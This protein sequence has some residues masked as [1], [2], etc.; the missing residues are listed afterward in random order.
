MDIPFTRFTDRVVRRGFSRYVGVVLTSAKISS[1]NAVA[2]ALYV[3]AEERELGSDRSSAR[4][5]YYAGEG[6]WHGSADALAAAGLAGARMDAAT[7]EA[8]LDGRDP[9]TGLQLRRRGANGVVN[10]HDL[11]FA[12]PKPVSTLWAGSSAEQRQLLEQVIHRAHREAMRYLVDNT[13]CVHQRAEG[14]SA[15]RERVVARELVY[16]SMLHRTARPTPGADPDPHLHIHT[17]IVGAIRDRDGRLVTPDSFGWRGYRVQEVGAVFEA[18]VGRQL[19]ELGLPTRMHGAWRSGFAIEGIESS[20]VDALSKRAQQ[21]QDALARFRDE[22]QRSPSR[23]EGR[24]LGLVDRQAKIG[25]DVDRLEATW[26]A[27]LAEHGVD[28]PAIWNARTRQ[29][30]TT[31]HVQELRGRLLDEL[32]GHA[33]ISDEQLRQMALR[34]GSGALDAKQTLAQ[35]EELRRDGQILTLESGYVTSAAVRHAERMTLDASDELAGL[36]LDRPAS[37][38]RTFQQVIGEIERALPGELSVEQCDAA[39]RTSVDGRRLNIVVGK[40][41]SGKGEVISTISACA[42]DAGQ[43]V[44]V[45]AV[46]GG[47]AQQA[48]SDALAPARTIASTLARMDRG[49]EPI[50]EG[51]VLIVDEA[52]MVDTHQLWDLLDRAADR[53]LQV[54]LVGDLAQIQAIGPGGMLA[55]LIERHGCIELTE[56][57]RARHA[58]LRHAQLAIREARASE[59][60]ATY[61]QHGALHVLDTTNDAIAQMVERWDTHRHEHKLAQSLMIVHDTNVTVDLVNM[62]AQERRL[63]AGELG[64]RSAPSPDRDYQLYE[65]DLVVFRNAPYDVGDGSPRVEN[66][67]R[68]HIRRIDEDGTIHVLVQEP[69]Q[70]H[71]TIAVDPDR[72]PALRLA[73]A[74]HTMPAQGV[75]VERSYELLN[76]HAINRHN[77][78]VGASRA[79]ERHDVF[80]PGDALD[81]TGTLTQAQMLQRL[82]GA[83]DS[84]TQTGASLTLEQIDRT[85]QPSVMPRTHR[86]W[87]APEIERAEQH[88]HALTATARELEQQLATRSTQREDLVTRRD[89]T[90]QAL[91]QPSAQLDEATR[92]VADAQARADSARL[93]RGSKEWQLH[94]E[95][96]QLHSAQ[97]HFKHVNEAATAAVR[98]LSRHDQTTSRLSEQLDSIR[99]QIKD[100]QRALEFAADPALATRELDRIRHQHEQARS[101]PTGYRT[102]RD[103]L[104]AFVRANPDLPELR[105]SIGP[106]P[107]EP[108]QRGSWDTAATAILSHRIEHRIT[109]NKTTLGPP[110]KTEQALSLSRGYAAT[111]EIVTKAA[112]QLSHATTQPLAPGL[113][114]QQHAAQLER[115]ALQRTRSRGLER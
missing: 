51:G 86:P 20:A 55:Q 26:S 30:P 9:A 114:Q 71:R 49:N 8:V 25:V 31:R 72:C 91:V 43:D 19:R 38:P 101:Q 80:V 97:Q 40:A 78:Y 112:H 15:Q 4:G 42:R 60:L 100:A 110:P 37:S 113:T 92:A 52:G 11:T 105:Q 111:L 77:A 70:Q 59:A 7:I 50:R 29:L 104:H 53:N 79:R 81:P 102:T 96:Q 115:A 98:E 63:H 56:I 5:R 22:Q 27:I 36:D 109:D 73:Y 83:I 106:R 16:G 35:V 21:V 103:D 108:R 10:S 65:R 13:P 14:D 23:A 34:I 93:F 3:T 84:R 44:L 54:V 76:V 48:G 87:K 95:Q 67:T 107:T 18:S 66:G 88:L 85:L 6:R 12:V 24:V 94:L 62:L 99:P 17:L 47:R 41:G 82:A 74:S 32:S 33:M 45:V 89:A 69:G 68:G 75:T 2:Y 57:H 46:V 64:T 58:W 61:R 1:S 28:A 39:R 90:Q